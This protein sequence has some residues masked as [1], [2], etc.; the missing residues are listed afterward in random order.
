MRKLFLFFIIQCLITISGYSQEN[1]KIP[2]TNLSINL[3]DGYTVDDS[4]SMIFSENYSVE[5]TETSGIGFPIFKRN[6]E[7]VEAML[8]NS[9]NPIKEKSTKK[10]NQ[11]EGQYFSFDLSPATDQVYFG[12]SNFWASATI[13]AKDSSIAIDDAEINN[14]LS[15]IEYKFDANHVMD[16]YANFTF[17]DIDSTWTLSSF[18]ANSFG[19]HHKKSDDKILLMQAPLENTNFDDNFKKRV[20]QYIQVLR[21]QFGR[22]QV[23]KQVGYT[24]NGIEGHKA[25]V[26]MYDRNKK[27]LIYLFAF[28]SDKSKFIFQGNGAKYNA[29]TVNMFE[30]V[31][32]NLRL[33]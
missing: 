14:L 19:Y 3:L 2:N 20:T 24:V 25:I 11:Y 27:R 13:T 6:L 32:E 18:R 16:N 29:K 23:V 21:H 17:D 9:G 12:D 31:L 1:A 5:F 15:S 26:R 33:K 30:E 28:S 8:I 10:V 4:L 22:V 7:K